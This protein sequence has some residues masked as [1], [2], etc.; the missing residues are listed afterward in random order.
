MLP[1]ARLQAR[2][3]VLWRSKFICSKA[4]QGICCTNARPHIDIAQTS[5]RRMVANLTK[6]SGQSCKQRCKPPHHV[7]GVL[8]VEMR[9]LLNSFSLCNITTPVLGTAAKCFQQPRLLQP[10]KTVHRDPTPWCR[11]PKPGSLGSRALSFPRR[12]TRGGRVHA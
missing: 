4:S 7:G 1:H 9:N 2:A 11:T 8:R 10:K 12:E 5:D 6:A 3:H